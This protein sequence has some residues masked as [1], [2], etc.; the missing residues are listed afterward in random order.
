[1]LAGVKSEMTTTIKNGLHIL[2]VFCRKGFMSGNGAIFGDLH[3]MNNPDDTEKEE[4]DM[5][6]HIPGD[7][8]PAMLGPFVMAVSFNL[9][10]PPSVNPATGD[11]GDLPHD[12]ADKDE[13]EGNPIPGKKSEGVIPLLN[14]NAETEVLVRK[15]TGGETKISVLSVSVLVEPIVDW[16]EKIVFALHGDAN[17][18][19]GAELEIVEVVGVPND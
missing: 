4:G 14:S 7:E 2:D 10:A 19:G 8:L 18:S 13:E 5:P 1:M 12:P 9:N 6:N 17:G 3:R 11:N 16:K 15:L